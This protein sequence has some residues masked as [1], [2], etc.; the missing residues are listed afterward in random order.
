MTI[1]RVKGSLRICAHKVGEGGSCR[2]ERLG[3]HTLSP[4][5][6]PLRPGESTMICGSLTPNCSSIAACALWFSLISF[7]SLA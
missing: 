7:R 6:A 4:D 1:Q 3:I 2:R 5:F